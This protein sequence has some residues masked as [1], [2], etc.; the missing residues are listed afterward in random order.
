MP[1]IERQAPALADAGSAL[2]RTTSTLNRRSWLNALESAGLRDALRAT[3]PFLSPEAGRAGPD[4]R[5]SG[6]AS[7][8]A[9]DMGQKE[10][11]APIVFA[12]RGQPRGEDQS[13]PTIDSGTRQ[14]CRSKAANPGR[15][16]VFLG[17]PEMTLAADCPDREA[18]VLTRNLPPAAPQAKRQWQERNIV[19][20]PSADGMEVW[21]R[22]SRLRESRL[23][24]LLGTLRN[25]MAE[26]GT[27]LVRVSLNG[28]PVQ[29]HAQARAGER[30]SKEG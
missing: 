15:P 9:G 19:A 11:E 14:S 28:K 2:P 3:K 12:D 16:Q 27:S 30:N 13:G 6:Q 26:L 18:D 22:D 21:I 1:N 10:D 20:L 23:A 4:S 24:T 5:S 8:P 17:P 7:W 29:M 25:T